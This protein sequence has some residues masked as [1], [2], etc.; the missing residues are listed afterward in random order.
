MT[1]SF[2]WLTVLMCLGGWW[3]YLMINFDGMLSHLDKMKFS[4]MLFWEGSAFIVLL[5]LICISLLIFYVRDHLK[6]KS[7]QDFFA[8]LTHE[9]KTPLASIKLQGEVI[10]ELIESKNEPQLKNLLNRLTEDT[11][12]LETQMDK[13]LQLSRIERGGDVNLSNVKVVPFIKNIYKFWAKDFNLEIDCTDHETVVLVDEFA[14]EL[15][16]K[17]LFENTKNHSKSK[18][19]KITIKPISPFT[20][21]IYRDGGKFNGDR[22]KIA[23]LFYKHNSTKG[24]GIGL[25][26]TKKLTDKMQGSFFITFEPE[27]VF[28]FHLKSSEDKNA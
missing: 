14:F 12:K 11:I 9:L 15:I 8:S 28:E 7:L 24:S 13:I 21:L 5:I 3:I 6:T 22:H 4:K 20:H 23:T 19:V 10:G 2:L 1:L 16:L 18:N 27:I 25:Y 17:N 26:L